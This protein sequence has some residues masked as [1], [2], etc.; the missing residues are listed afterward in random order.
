MQ[1][2]YAFGLLVLIA[3]IGS[4]FVFKRRSF[5][6][7]LTFFFLSGLIY[8]LLGLYL[9]KHG[10]NV[11]SSQALKGLIPLISLGLG[12]I[13]FLFGF[14][15]EYKYLRKFPG[16]FIG[17]SVFQSL[18]VFFLA[19]SVLFLVSG[20]LLSSHPSYL[21]YGMAVAFSLLVSLNSPTLLNAA[22]SVIQKKGN[23]YYL[24][25][26]L[27]SVSGFWGLVGLALLSSFWHF[28]FFESRVFARGLIFF[29]ASTIFP[30]CLAYVFHVLTK[31]KT[32]EQDLLVYLLGLVFFVSGAAFYFNLPSL[33]V[34]MVLGITYSNLT[35]VQERIYP[36]LFSTEK[37]LYIVF[38][39]LIGALWEFNFDY[40]IA[41]LVIL[42][43]ITRVAG[44]SFPL[45]LY[46][47][48]LRFSFPLPA[49]FGLC[50]L[51]F[52]GIGVAFAVSLKLAYPIPLTDTFLSVALLAII[53]SEI[54]SPWA[55]KISLLKLDR[56]ERE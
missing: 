19:F 29:L 36:L 14:Q 8:I 42:V 55:L 34:C 3:F 50:F 41:L 20:F 18:F 16:K 17:L 4:R 21:L 37:P 47:K 48:L 32:S 25:R 5:L 28:P 1:A 31:K 53:L 45:P 9:G 51:S 27:V 56:E 7:P 22:S 49:R 40:K 46:K 54:L 13:G 15:L 26:F 33:Y 11:L 24:A 44:Y 2:V 30:F 12:W 38:L 39:I 23:Y 52:G 43:F 10:L 35:K 6:S